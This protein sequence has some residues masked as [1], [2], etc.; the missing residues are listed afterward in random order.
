MAK[1]KSQA[2]TARS[3]QRPTANPPIARRTQYLVRLNPESGKL[4]HGIVGGGVYHADQIYQVSEA[5]AA[6]MRA[7]RSDARNPS[8]PPV[9]LVHTTEEARA[10]ERR[11]IEQS[12]ERSSSIDDPIQVADHAA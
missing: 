12:R 8:S 11:L 1:P 4:T 2:Q 6:V 5:R 9:F 10:Y 3:V 7:M